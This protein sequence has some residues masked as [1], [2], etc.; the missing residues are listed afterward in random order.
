M[1]IKKLQLA[2]MS[3]ALAGMIG[4]PSLFA[5]T[6]LDGTLSFGPSTFQYQQ[7]GEFNAITSGL[8][9]FGTFCLE[10]GEFIAQPPSGPYTYTI[11]TG[12]VQGGPGATTTDPN[13]PTLA[14]D[15]VSLGTAWLYSQFAAGTL[16]LD[17][18]TGSYF[19]AN[20]LANAGE[21]QQAIW[22]LEDEAPGQSNGY[23]VLAENALSETVPQIE[24]DS[25]GAYGVVALN[26]FNQDGSLAQDQLAVVPQAAPEPT[27]AG[28]FLL[29]L[30][31][32]AFCRR[33]NRNRE[34]RL[35]QQARQLK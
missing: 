13:N 2:I 31:A 28:C 22:Y 33:F 12:A 17:T 1:K 6:G 4:A 32:L 16:T 11:N 35:N 30:G 34:V 14:M 25:L 19:D 8:G 10:D 24:A 7:G 9:S 23:V 3:T 5:Y 20:H 26:L 18:G 21:L 15:N 27:T 29:G